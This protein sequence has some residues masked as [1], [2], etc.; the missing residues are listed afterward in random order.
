MPRDTMGRLRQPDRRP[1][2][3]GGTR[4]HRRDATSPDRHLLVALGVSVVCGEIRAQRALEIG[5]VTKA[6]LAAGGGVTFI[7]FTFPHELRASGHLGSASVVM[8]ESEGSSC[9]RQ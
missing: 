1:R 9:E 3:S 2:R 6:H 5:H 7:T 8:A 4:R